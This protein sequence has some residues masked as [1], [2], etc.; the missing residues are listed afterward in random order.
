MLKSQI[1]NFKLKNIEVMLS[2]FGI[3]LLSKFI[4][5][6]WNNIVTIQDE[7]FV[8]E[9]I[10]IILKILW[11]FFAFALIIRKIIKISLIYFSLF[12]GFITLSGKITNAHV[13]L[14]FIVSVIF[15]FCE[16]ESRFNNEGIQKKG[17]LFL[18]FKIQLSIVYFFAALAKINYDFLSGASL[19]FFYLST[20]NLYKYESV[21]GASDSL[22]LLISITS[23]LIEAFLSFAFWIP[24]VKSIALAV[25]ITFHTLMLI[26]LSEDQNVFL[27]LVT[28]MLIM[29]FLM[30]F[31]WI[32]DYQ[33][34]YI[35]WD[36]T[37]SFC[38]KFIS[39]L[40]K[41][42]LN[43][44]ITFIGSS[45]KMQIENFNI[46]EM[47]LLNSI[48]LVNENNSV[49]VQGYD[50]IIYALKLNPITLSINPFMNFRPIRSIGKRVYRHVAD[51]RSCKI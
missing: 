17:I 36:D 51:R 45:N 31:F 8:N 13:W 11:L 39:I 50:A 19:N 40:V 24:K 14:I 30:N 27:E 44:V 34:V 21:L 3:I 25:G 37:C 33:K 29:Y 41:L 48:Q 43:N 1:E 5:L 10:V 18:S 4:T 20:N 23:I 28:F 32:A 22:Y 9:K 46:P 26:F 49:R 15:L 35:I 16:I 38:A 12:L 47:D 2:F 42:N 7:I 6:K